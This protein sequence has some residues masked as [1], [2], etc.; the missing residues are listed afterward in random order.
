MRPMIRVQAKPFDPVAEL[1]AFRHDDSGAMASFIGYC[2]AHHGDAKVEALELE[3]YPGFTESEIARIV[4]DVRTRGV[5]RG[6]QDMLVVHRTGRIRPGEAIVL[7]AALSSHRAE[8][9]AAVEEVMD[10]LKTDA[11]FWKREIRDDGAHWI[12]PT[13]ADQARAGQ[14]K[15]G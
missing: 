8:A 9:F 2:R 15:R 12:E 6:L 1:A 11:P 3:H 7:V 10:Y 5:R 14:H 13:A 4:D